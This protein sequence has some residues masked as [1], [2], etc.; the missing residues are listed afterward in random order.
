MSGTGSG[1]FSITEQ[2]D[3]RLIVGVRGLVRRSLRLMVALSGRFRISS[4][5]G[6]PERD[7]MKSGVS[8]SASKIESEGGRLMTCDRLCSI[9]CQV[10][11]FAGRSGSLPPFPIS[12]DPLS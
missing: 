6:V 5:T 8:G 11:T 1:T 9:S 2:S 7:K 3:R 4:G 10:S 12:E